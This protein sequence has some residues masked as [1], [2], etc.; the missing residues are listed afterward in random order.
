MVLYNNNK[1]CFLH[2]AKS[3]WAS[4]FK[5]NQDTLEPLRE[6]HFKF[7]QGLDFLIFS[8][9][10]KVEDDECMARRSGSTSNLGG[11]NENQ[12]GQGIPGKIPP[13]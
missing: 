11:R 12:V 2:K 9:G 4:T 7:D 5:D 6:K 10:Q 13:E 8:Q 3:S 1:T